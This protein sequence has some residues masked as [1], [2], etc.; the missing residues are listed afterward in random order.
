[1]RHDKVMTLKNL[2]ELQKSISMTTRCTVARQTDSQEMQQMRHINGSKTEERSL[3]SLMSGKV[4]V[5][6]RV[7]QSL[8]RCSGA[9]DLNYN[10][11]MELCIISN[12]LMREMTLRS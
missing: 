7:E 12:E 3:G 11:L 10:E 1:M 5:F 8:R 2:K 4:D 9:E 6:D